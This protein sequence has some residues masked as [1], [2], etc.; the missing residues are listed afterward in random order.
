M[1]ENK[2]IVFP[3]DFL[4]GGA[5]SAEQT[6]G[7]FKGMDKGETIYDYSFKKNPNNFRNNIG[8]DTA[9]KLI[10]NYKSDIQD[11]KSIKVNSLRTSMSWARIFP[12]GDYNKPN[13]V[14]V[15]WYHSFIDELIKNGI[16]PIM[17]L[18]HFDMPM[19]A[20][21]KGGWESRE[22][23]NE[24]LEYSKFV[25]NEFGSKI[26][27]WTTMNEPWVPIWTGYFSKV[28]YPR[29]DNDQRGINAAYGIVMSHGLV[30]NY[31][32][33]NIKNKYNTKIGAI[34][35]SGVVYPKDKNNKEDVKAAKYLEMYQLTGLTDPMI[36]GKWNDGLIKWVKEMDLVPQNY[37]KID[38]ETL[39]HVKVDWVGIN[40][41][42]PQ[43]AM[44]PTR[45]DNKH[46]M[47]NYFESYNMP[48][49]RENKFRGWEIYPEAIYDTFKFFN[50]R[51]SK[52]L[53]Y[54][55]TEFGMGVENE[56]VFRNEDGI[57]D[58]QYRISFIKEHLENLNRVMVEEKSMKIIG[59]HVWAIIDCWSWGNA[60]KNR[61]GLFEVDIKTQMRKPKS[62]AYFFK[63]MIEANGFLNNYPLMETYIDYDKL[64]FTDS[65]KID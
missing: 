25:F 36:T 44:A 48:G 49:R 28:E 1:K 65:I 33:A 51:Y 53:E 43:R 21:N 58:D 17:T 40:Y 11:W 64:I 42:S 47:Y 31:F 37:L 54:M 22:V 19:Y 16:E 10:E 3:E 2:K 18:F 30:V 32:N 63:K 57:I 38:I 35:N 15:K 23:W 14:A 7:S 50:K 61:Y 59:A 55:L 13:M 46:K 52:D 45:K 29:I 26:K 62:S 41:Y 34:F 6:E 56:G 9:I 4:W 8:P 27:R 12:D 20:Q 24:F 5:I 60:F 39:S